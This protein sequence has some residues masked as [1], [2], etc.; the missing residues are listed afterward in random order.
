MPPIHRRQALARL[1]LAALAPGALAP[2]RAQGKWPDKP[3]KLV[4][5]F[6]AGVSPD[7]V[8]R[9]VSEPL[10]RALGQPLLVDNRAGAAGIIGAEVAAK[11]PGDGYTLFMTVN[12]IMGINPNV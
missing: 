6:A 2:A 10:G 8:A 4:V 9:I 11:S 12:S 5:P 7:V 1:G 3:I